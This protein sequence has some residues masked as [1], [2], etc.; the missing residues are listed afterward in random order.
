MVKFHEFVYCVHEQCFA[1]AGCNECHHRTPRILVPHERFMDE[2]A[3][4]FKLVGMALAPCDTHGLISKIYRE[5]PVIL[6]VR[7]L[8]AVVSPE[9]FGCA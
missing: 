2:D 9:V 1:A 7:F 4:D 5:N 6:P 3:I 8:V